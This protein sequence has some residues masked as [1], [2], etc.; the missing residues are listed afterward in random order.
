[1]TGSKGIKDAEG[2]TK[3]GKGAAGLKKM[4]GMILKPF[5]WIGKI[6]T[7]QYA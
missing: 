5:I 6:K 4:F 3:K 1:M 2:V 7:T